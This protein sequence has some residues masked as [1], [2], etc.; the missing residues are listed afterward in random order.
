MHRRKKRQKTDPTSMTRPSSPSMKNM[1][2]THPE[3]VATIDQQTA[4]LRDKLAQL[5][6]D[7]NKPE[8]YKAIFC[9]TSVVQL[10]QEADFAQGVRPGPMSTLLVAAL[11]K[12]LYDR[13]DGQ[14]L[15]EGNSST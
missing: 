10:A 9:V 13:F 12:F 1:G 6:V 3:L 7:P 14:D 8:V 11:S 2:E 4:D 15:P 5:D